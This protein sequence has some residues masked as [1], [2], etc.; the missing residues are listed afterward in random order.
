MANIKGYKI[1]R[2]ISLLF[3]IAVIALSWQGY[4]STGD[5]MLRIGV[6]LAAFALISILTMVFNPETRK[7]Y[8]I[9]AIVAMVLVAFWYFNRQ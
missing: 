8:L 1:T 5:R 7:S 2:A 6:T 3:T 4:Y 9:F